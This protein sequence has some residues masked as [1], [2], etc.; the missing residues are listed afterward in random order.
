LIYKMTKTKKPI[1]RVAMLSVHT[2][3]L[4]TL[5]G[6]EAGG[7]NVYVRELSKE[8]GRRGVQVDVFTRTQSLITP[9]THTLSDNTRI[10]HL[11]A[12]PLKPYDKNEIYKHLPEFVANIR[13]F[14]RSEASNYDMIHGHYWLSG[15]AGLMLRERWGVPVVQM[16]HTLAQLKNDTA[17]NDQQREPDF[18][19][20]QEGE[21]MRQVDRIVAATSVEKAD[22]SWRY[23][24]DQDKIEPIPCGVDLRM[25]RPFP[26]DEARRLLG[27][28]EA[29]PLILQ[30]GRIDPIK[31]V[32]VLIRAANEMVRKGNANFQVLITGGNADELEHNPE[33]VRLRILV[34]EFG[35]EEYVKFLPSQPQNK[36]AYLYSAADITVI[37]SHYES[38]GMVALESQACG[39]P[40]VASRVGGLPYAVQDKH[41]GL[42]FPDNDYQELA[43]L[44][45]VLLVNPDYRRIMGQQAA[46][47]AELF[48]WR[49]VADRIIALYEELAQ[50][51]LVG[52]GASRAGQGLG[53]I[54]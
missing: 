15:V 17:K 23:G 35:L 11:P 5:G 10:I 2:C 28:A 3:P 7:M 8:L 27:L 51:A 40:V 53:I 22:L 52:Q 18:R 31:G 44:I 38:F 29:K 45:G 54:G 39:T 47:R 32:D 25:F 41:S 6:K 24:A 42:L 16:F 30:V 37:P 21:I 33:A 50:P 13:N 26:K 43:R 19:A 36:M 9:L 12:G 14:A 20:R 46:M 4:A 1:E 34:E 49:N 48:G